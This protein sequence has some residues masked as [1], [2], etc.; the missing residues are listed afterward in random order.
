MGTLDVYYKLKEKLI[1]TPARAHCTF[2]L[3]DLSRVFAGL[4]LMSVPRG[5]ATCLQT[6]AVSVVR[7]WCHEVVR[8][9]ADRLLTSEGSVPLT[10]MSCINS[11]MIIINANIFI[12]GVVVLTK[13]LS[14]QCDTM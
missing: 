3:H 4:S 13:S 10:F 14:V 11:Y 1:A 2:S 6:V 12:V 5:G 8:T 9:F 7:L